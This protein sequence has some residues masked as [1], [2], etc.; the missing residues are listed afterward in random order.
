MK[1]N[2]LVILLL[3][4]VILT[5][6]CT[7]KSE[8]IVSSPDSK[9][10][11]VIEYDREQG[12]LTYHV[13]SGEK[14]IISPSRMGINTD[15][16]DFSSGVKLKKAASGIVDENYTL[17]QGKVSEYHNSA[18]EQILTVRKGKQSLDIRFRVYDDGVAFR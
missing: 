6:S 15:A 8:F 4:T 17:P 12:M 7:L 9:I 2:Q 13:V 14:D 3:F 10:K 16:G 11:A 5:G 18:N 1:L